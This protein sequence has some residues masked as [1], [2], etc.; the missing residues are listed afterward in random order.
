LP[1]RQQR[2]WQV[3]FIK[4]QAIINYTFTMVLVGKL[5]ATQFNQAYLL[6]DLLLELLMQELSFMQRIHFYFIT[7]MVLHG[8]KLTPLAQ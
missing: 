1:Q 3:M 2:H 8:H 4:T 6:T 7:Q 5:L